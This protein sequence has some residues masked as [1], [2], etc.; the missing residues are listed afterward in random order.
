M[1][2]NRYGLPRAIPESVKR[3]VRQRCGFGCVICGLGFYEYE[4]FDPDFAYA[5][6]HMPRGMTPLC[7]QCNRKRARG[8]LSAETV[9]RWNAHPKCREQGFANEWFDFGVEPIEV[10]FAGVSFYECQHL[11]VIDD[12]PLLGVLPPAAVGQPV[13]LS[14][15]FADRYG[16]TSLKIERNEWRAATHNWDVECVGPRITVR[17]GRGDIASMLRMDP[18]H[19]LV[20][21]RLDM[22]L[23][24]VCL[25][26]DEKTL[27]FSMNG[28]GWTKFNAC[29]MQHCH[30]GIGIANGGPPAANASLFDDIF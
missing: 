7:S 10:L 25:V 15:R 11:V 4:H 16:R 6:E 9:S 23:H 21:E 24:G 19:R 5:K 14:G 3:E 30:I 17:K 20:V 26:G 2:S 1:T 8:R 12:V 18:P 13:Q 27:T 28:R 29:S 22:Y